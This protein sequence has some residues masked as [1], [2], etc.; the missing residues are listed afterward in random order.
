[1]ARRHA[2]STTNRKFLVKIVS[3]CLN[4]DNAL[5]TNGIDTHTHIPHIL[6][7]ATQLF[8]Q[9]VQ[10]VVNGLFN[11]NKNSQNH[12]HY[13]P[14]KLNLREPKRLIPMKSKTSRS[15]PLSLILCV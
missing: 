9:T 15:L 4:E 11:Q 8:H 2:V 7:S 1:M 6:A 13:I 14:F 5:R 10:I 3:F 12:G